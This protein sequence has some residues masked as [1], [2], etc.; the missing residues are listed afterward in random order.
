[1]D[2]LGALERSYDDAGRV[3]ADLKPG[4]LTKATPCPGWDVRAALD[5]LLG[6]IRMFTNAANG[7]PLPDGLAVDLSGDD[8]SGSFAREVKASLAAWRAPGALA[9]VVATPLGAL[10][11]EV[12]VSLG[13]METAAHLHDIASGVG[14]PAVIDDALGEFL[15]PFISGLPLDGI[16]AAGEF[17][18]EVATTPDAPAVERF[19]GLLGRR[20]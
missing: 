6:V 3:I 10:P 18:P 11:G 15:L 17:G 9:K 14:R 4:D 2:P 20:A 19:L 1:M 8:P 7:E 12:A 13:A 5:H 16:R